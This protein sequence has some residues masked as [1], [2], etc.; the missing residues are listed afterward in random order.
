MMNTTQTDTL[1]TLAAK[2][3]AIDHLVVAKNGSWEWTRGELSA[4]FKQVETKDNWKMPID[5]DVL[6]DNDRDLFGL[7]EAVIFFTGSVPT[8][9]PLRARGGKTLYNVT[10]AGYY[11]VIG[12]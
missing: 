5:A 6:L 7:R 11:A 1:D 9:R 4:Y 2:L 8:F 12:A 10:A 3:E